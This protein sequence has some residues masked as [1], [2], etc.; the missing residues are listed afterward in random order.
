MTH[1]FS[2]K[3]A[4]ERLAGLQTPKNN[5][6]FTNHFQMVFL[7]YVGLLAQLRNRSSLIFSQASMLFLIG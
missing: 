5:A 2:G 6:T 7:Y 4:S 3:H 1:L